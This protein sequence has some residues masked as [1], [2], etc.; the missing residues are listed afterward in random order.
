MNRLPRLF[1]FRSNCDA[2]DWALGL[3]KP[4][5]FSVTNS[6]A[7]LLLPS[8][9]VMSTS[10]LGS[11]VVEPLPS[12]PPS[13]TSEDG[14]NR[15]RV[16]RASLESHFG[17]QQPSSSSCTG[18]GKEK[19]LFHQESEGQEEEDDNDTIEGVYPPSGDAAAET[20][21]VQ[22][23]LKRWEVAER[24]RRKAAR[25]SVQ[26]TTGPSVLEDVT[27]KASLI[28]SGRR[29]LQRASARN[30]LGD[31][32]ALK[33]HDSVDVVPL[34]DIDRSPQRVVYSPTPSIG[35]GNNI[36]TTTN[37]PNPFI[38]PS[39]RR[40]SL[41]PP[42]TAVVDS[43]PQSPAATGPS[44]HSQRSN[45]VPRPLT[46]SPLSLPVPSPHVPPS[47]SNQKPLSPTPPLVIGPPLREE[48]PQKRV[49]WWHEWLCGCGEGP[50]R[51]G[52][53]QAARTNP[54]E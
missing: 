18:K 28:L 15:S 49:R 51:G 52:D 53:H 11:T 16:W 24:Q 32:R 35:D 45:T 54:F 48:E 2:C 4:I 3:P 38:H 30:G 50:D 46:G 9:S 27:R 22:E 17:D 43:I 42:N 7:A 47:I 1:S 39:E 26:M 41:S 8:S 37:H 14:F 13:P 36:G 10:L 21:R 33:S 40:L 20:R 23:T 31:H 34:G 44:V 5:K 6:T 12:L 25:E 29:P 19:Q